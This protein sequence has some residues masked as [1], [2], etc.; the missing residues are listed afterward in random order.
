MEDKINSSFKYVTFK[1]FD[2]Q[3]N[4]GISETCQALVKGVPFSDANNA[5]KYNAGLDVINT[6]SKHYDT[7]CPIFFDNRESVNRLI[8][9]DSQIV[10]LIVSQDK[11]LRVA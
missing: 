1:M 7:T 10:N 6:L 9:T 11:A 2:V 5:S 4:G 8:E 3:V